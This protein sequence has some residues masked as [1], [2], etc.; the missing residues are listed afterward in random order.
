MTDIEVDR[1]IQRLEKYRE[2][3]SKSKKKSKEFLIGA[4]IITPEGNL[5]SPYKHLCIPPEQA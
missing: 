3:V 4:G 2:R 1:L 5:T